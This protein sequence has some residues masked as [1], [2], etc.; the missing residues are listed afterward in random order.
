MDANSVRSPIDAKLSEQIR[1]HRQIQALINQDQPTGTRRSLLAQALRLTKEIAP[2]LCASLEHCRQALGVQTEVELY[3]YS[4]PQFNAGCTRQEGNRVFVLVSSALLEAFAPDE[5][6]FVLGHE[7]GHHHYHHHEI[8]LAGVLS[9][10]SNLDRSL[11]L[12]VFTWQRHAEVSADRAGMLCCGGMEPAARSLF[13]LASGLRAAPSPER[14]GAFIEQAKELH[15]VSV[16]GDSSERVNHTDW[17]STHPFSPIRMLACQAFAA[18]SVFEEGGI[19]MAEVELE[20]QA[21]MGLMEASYL[22]ADSPEAEAMRRLLFAAGLFL[23]A[24]DG[25]IDPDEVTSLEKLLGPGSIPRDPSLER[26]KPYLEER[27]Q[28]VAEQVALPRRAQLVRDLALL[29][30]AD[31][32]VDDEERKF[33]SDIAQR[34]SVDVA[35]VEGSLSG[36]LALD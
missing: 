8:P 24:S 27:I 17:L 26:L 12:K 29:A 19:S 14:I 30:R 5:L 3:V 28:T 35:L 34:L 6:Q 9:P 10:E 22:D 25:E 20:V 21:H 31:G 32:R 13:K 23:S 11:I 7:L 1:A 18:S 16:S 4:S 2:E 15:R 36:S 33:L